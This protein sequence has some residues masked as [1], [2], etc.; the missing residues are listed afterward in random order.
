M[1]TKRHLCGDFVCR[2]QLHSQPFAKCRQPPRIRAECCCYRESSVVRTECVFTCNVRLRM[3]RRNG[4]LK[5]GKTGDSQ[6]R[7]RGAWPTLIS[8]PLCLAYQLTILVTSLTFTNVRFKNMYSNIEPQV[9]KK[10]T[11]RIKR[12]LSVPHE[13]LPLDLR[14]HYKRIGKSARAP[15]RS[16]CVF[17][18]VCLNLRLS[19]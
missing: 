16:A 8:L 11:Q 6:H 18:I 12:N 2:E 14:S 10:Q 4:N 9:N 1:Q 5:C 19:F 17:L 7:A 3:E 15:L 13:L